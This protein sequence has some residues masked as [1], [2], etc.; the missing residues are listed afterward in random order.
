MDLVLLQVADSQ[1]IG[2]VVGGSTTPSVRGLARRYPTKSIVF[3]EMPKRSNP[4]KS[5]LPTLDQQ[6]LRAT[7]GGATLEIVDRYVENQPN[8]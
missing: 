4:V 3:T 5:R 6:L 1:V 2:D 8:T 7:T